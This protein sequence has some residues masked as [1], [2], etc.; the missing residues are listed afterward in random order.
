MIGLNDV[1][2]RAVSRAMPTWRAKFS[3]G[4]IAAAI[5]GSPQ[6]RDFLAR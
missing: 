4:V 1:I 5:L 2:R 3:W 6:E